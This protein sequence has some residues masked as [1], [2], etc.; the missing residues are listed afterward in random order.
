VQRFTSILSRI[1]LL[2]G[3]AVVVTAIFIPLALY[4]ALNADVENLQR[5]AMREEAESLARHLTP[6]PDGRWSLD[7]P[8][9]LR[10]QFSEAYGRYAYAVLD[11]QGRVLFSSRKDGAPIFPDDDRSTDIAFL[12]TRRDD[13]TIIGASLQ[14]ET[15]G[16]AAWVQVGEDLSHRGVLVNDV[17]TNFFERVGWITVPILLVMLAT[18]ILIFR[19]AVQPL[20][21]V[22]RRAEH[23][24]PTRIDVRL[25]VEDIPREIRPLVLAVN[26][27]LDRLERGFRRQREFTADAAHEL[28]TPLAV[29]RTRI[30]TLPDRHTAED[31]CRDVEAMS[32]VVG[33]LLDAAEVETLVVASNE[34]ADLQKICAEVV[35]FIAPLAL[36]QEKSIGLSG[37]EAPVQVVGNAEMVN[38]AIR[39]LVENALKHTPAGT[40]VEIVVGDDAT[41]AVLDHG[42]GVPEEKRDKIFER[43]WRR[44]RRGAAGAGLGL[45]IVK[46]IMDVH[47]GTVTVGD[48]P[49]GGAN[50]ELRL[51]PLGVVMPAGGETLGPAEAESGTRRTYRRLLAA[52]AITWLAGAWSRIA[53]FWVFDF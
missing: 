5:W 33:Q 15:E 17:V 47:G 4:W 41:V 35:A 23:I 42:G 2:H 11:E 48:A 19:R 14:I 53:R 26:R 3:V 27:A 20:L 13:R 30:E 7:L 44:D 12:E 52:R 51:V 38:R 16:R 9:G 46:G 37:T 32:R 18:D 50:F 21:E 31:L 1:M 25:P 8:A 36:A 49:W 10:S 40:D 28:R 34:T 6:R 29:L 43:F 45:S 39:N 24:G 22:S